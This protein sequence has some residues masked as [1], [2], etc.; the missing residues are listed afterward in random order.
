MFGD[1]LTE[2]AKKVM[3]RQCIQPGCNRKMS[4]AMPHEPGD[5]IEP[6]C[7][8][9]NVYYTIIGGHAVTNNGA[10]QEF[11]RRWRKFQEDMGIDE[12][13]FN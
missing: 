3:S 12:N 9:C 13:V 1:L 7:D 4:K 6:I 11:N 8:A 5:P 2:D 10:T